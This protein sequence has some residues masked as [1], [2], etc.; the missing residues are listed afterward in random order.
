MAIASATSLILVFVGAGC[1][2]VGRYLLSAW[3]NTV[4]DDRWLGFALGT[5]AVNVMGSL[6]IG[7]CAGA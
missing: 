2:G 5:F 4:Q 1:G 7:V 3:I 6:L